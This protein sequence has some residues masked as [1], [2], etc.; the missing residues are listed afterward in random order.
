MV[1]LSTSGDA[2]SRSTAYGHRHLP[3]TE[4]SYR[5]D[6]RPPP[7]QSHRPAFVSSIG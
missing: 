2:N 6:L 1:G 7:F 5:L 3:A 4:L